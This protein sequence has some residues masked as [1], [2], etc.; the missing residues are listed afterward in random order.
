V[1][2]IVVAGRFVIRPLFRLLA[3]T[4]LREIF[5]AAALTLVIGITLLMELVGL[6]PA[7]GTF[8]AGVVLAESEYRHELEADVEPFKGLL[9]GVFFISVGAS[10]D[11]RTIAA[12]PGLIFGLVAAVMLVK[13]A[14]LLA[15]AKL[16]GLAKR[17]GY[18]LALALCEVGEFAFVLFSFATQARVL[19]EAVVAPLV[20]VVALSMLLTPLVLMAYERLL[21]PR[22]LEPTGPEREADE[23]EAKDG[24]V[25]IAGYGRFGQIVGR[26]LRASGVPCTVLDLDVE[27]VDVIRRIGFEVHYG[28]ASRLDLLVA[29]GCANARL[30]VLAVDDHEKAM[31][32]GETV[33][34]H[35]PKLPL[36]AR[37]RG[38]VEYYQM[39]AAIR[40]DAIVRETLGSAIELGEQ[41]LRAVGFR[42]HEAH[43]MARAF[44][45][46]DEA[47]ARNLTKLYSQPEKD[48]NAYFAAARDAL[49]ETE[50]LMKEES[51]RKFG[52]D[53]HGWDNESLRADVT[54][55]G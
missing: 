22:M 6:S 33:R 49:R 30:F 5:T 50:R 10:I 4:G 18:L 36:M 53:L 35:F 31:E 20:A 2:G 55:R 25:V 3:K 19:P 17:A 26:L 40:P 21:V 14:V 43:R 42:G 13:A 8:V 15:I 29:A 11:F 46:H 28:D 44:V 9:L 12:H 54:S 32:I 52:G 23:I 27:I 48:Q 38:R 34:K 1:G 24:A 41:A 16:F 45:R 47:A 7:L 51:T 37:A 39:M